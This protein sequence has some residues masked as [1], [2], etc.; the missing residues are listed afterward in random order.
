MSQEIYAGP[1][2][3]AYNS[4]AMQAEGEGGTVRAALNESRAPVASS[5]FGHVHELMRDQTVEISLRPF[6]NWSL[7]PTLL[8]F[9]V[10]ETGGS[11]PGTLKVGGRPHGGTYATQKSTVIWTPDGR[12]YTFP[13]TA[14]TSHPSL[15][16][17]V[18]RA[19]YGDI[20]LTGLSSFA[21]G[22]TLNALGVAGSLCSVVES[23][24]STP[25]AN[26][27][28][29][30]V[31]RGVWTGVW[32]TVA[33][34]GGE[35]NGVPIQAEDEWT[36]ECDVR[37]SSHGFQG[38]TIAMTLES[39]RFMARCRPFGPSHTQV[40]AQV[41]A[42]TLGQKLGSAALTLSGPGAKTIT[43]N[44]CE[45]TG[46]GFDFGGSQLGQGEIGFVTAMTDTLG[47]PEPLITFSS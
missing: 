5:F 19:L 4:V 28:L 10:V 13:R 43:L 18:D 41:A 44:N 30:D 25:A 24:A 45:V 8:P 27:S 20:R 26:F 32:G 11:T 7:L 23:A 17:G 16:L 37:Y 2:K 3:V 9:E 31:V 29:S 42:H 47:V 6:D 33:G 34:F 21:V 39:V 12:S 14:I 40:L 15:H 36:I 38:H 46:M 1:G 22:G 35:Q